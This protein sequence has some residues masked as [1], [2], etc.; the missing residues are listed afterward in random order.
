MIKKESTIK[1][2]KPSIS[3]LL[4]CHNRKKETL[5]CLQS[6]YKQIRE[7]NLNIHIT[8]VDDG[9]SDGTYVAVSEQFPMVELVKGS[10]SLF[11]SG[12]MRVA[13][14]HAPKSDYYLWLNDDVIPYDGSILSILKQEIS[15]KEKVVV[16]GAVKSSS[17]GKVAYGGMRRI[18]N[19]RLRFSVL[20]PFE[21]RIECD[22]TNG[23]FV[24]IPREIY[25][26]VGNIDPYFVHAHGDI[27]FGL[28]VIKAGYKII[29]SHA[30]VGEVETRFLEQ[31]V[32]PENN[33]LK[34]RVRLITDI[35][36]LHPKE[37]WFLC[38]RHCKQELLYSF[39]SP[40]VRVIR[41]KP[42]GFVRRPK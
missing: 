4:C 42:L 2:I 3:V 34:D 26:K 1:N 14:E 40:Y 33:K 21:K 22:T 8:L 18:S 17:S 11:W 27:D 13:Y 41:K 35:K 36:G 29:L 19:K 28:R 39:I 12:G 31:R 25:Q 32:Y 16:T 23:N 5:R 9:S 38:R 24:L 15:S 10:G 20:E 37:W 7:D 30:Y 6:L